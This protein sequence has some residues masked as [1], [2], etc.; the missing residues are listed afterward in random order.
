MIRSS[1]TRGQPARPEPRGE[2]PGVHRAPAELRVFAVLHD[3]P[4]GHG[5]VLQRLAHDLGRGDRHAVVAERHRP[6]PGHEADL[7]QLLALSPL[8]RR[9]DGEDVASPALAAGCRRTRSSSRRR[10][11]GRCWACSRSLVNPPATAAALPVAIVSLSSRP[12]SR[13]WTCGSI[14]PGQTIRPV[15]AD[16]R[17][18]GHGFGTR[19]AGRHEVG[20][21]CPLRARRRA[22]RRVR[23]RD[24]SPAHR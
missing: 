3:R 12:G 14:S 16:P 24:R 6:G 21:T 4:A 17:V 7:G 2:R 10:G 5:D 20:H 15:A 22:S 13:R 23:W 11:P 1:A 18:A 9:A 19:I 8:G